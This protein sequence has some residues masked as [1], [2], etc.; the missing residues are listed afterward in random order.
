MNPYIFTYD[1]RNRDYFNKY[2]FSSVILIDRRLCSLLSF[3]NPKNRKDG[4]RAK[5][6]NVDIQKESRKL[7]RKRQEEASMVPRYRGIITERRAQPELADDFIELDPFGPRAQDLPETASNY[8]AGS[9]PDP[10]L[11]G[12][13]HIL[14][15]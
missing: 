11:M 10:L 14:S 8:N 13:R 3:R 12:S 2:L 1:L 7:L 9:D 15:F 6:T 4:I 5:S